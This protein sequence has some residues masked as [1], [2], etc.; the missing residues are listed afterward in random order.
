MKRVRNL[1]E[2]KQFEK[3]PLNDQ[4]Q[5]SKDILKASHCH[6]YIEDFLSVT[7]YKSDPGRRSK[8]F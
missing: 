4:A 2:K 1:K 7:I 5:Y 6:V 3:I 8:L